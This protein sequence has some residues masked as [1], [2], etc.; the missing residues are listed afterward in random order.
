[1]KK[2]TQMPTAV[3]IT[4]DELIPLV[5]DGKNVACPV[6]TI[7]VS[8]ADFGAAIQGINTQTQAQ[9]DGVTQALQTA[10]EGVEENVNTAVN[11]LNDLTNVQFEN[12]SQAIAALP[13]PDTGVAPTDFAA[14]IEGINQNNQAQFTGMAQALQT[15]IDG[16]EQALE[17]AVNGLNNLVNV[18]FENLAS[19][20]ANL[21]TGGG[22][23][24]PATNS[25]QSGNGS[26]MNGSW[27]HYFGHALDTNWTI[28]TITLNVCQWTSTGTITTSLSFTDEN[29][30]SQTIYPKHQGGANTITGTGV[31]CY[32]ACLVGFTGELVHSYSVSG[33]SGLLY[34]FHVTWQETTN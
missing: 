7:A 5:Q 9:I 28:V 1:M 2:I 33:G 31:Y 27:T 25:F 24:L 16:E 12:L 19:A 21:P 6:G 29:S 15:A 14:A 4:G 20:I 3:T 10:I 32:N 26:A 22:G 18:Q 30:N 11:G 17:A 23:S 34:D 13:I 8:P